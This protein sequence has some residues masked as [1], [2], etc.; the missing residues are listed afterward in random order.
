MIR[1]LVTVALLVIAACDSQSPQQPFSGVDVSHY[2]GDV[3]WNVVEAAGIHFAFAK[4]TQG[5]HFIDP[6]F[7]A[8]WSG[9]AKTKII[10]G[11]YHFLDPDVD[12]VAQATHFLGTVNFRSGDLRPVVDV[13]RSGTHLVETL[14]EFL[15]EVHKQLGIDAII[16]VSP[17]FW[18]EHIAPKLEGPLPNPLWSAEYEVDHPK[19]TDKLSAYS[20]WQYTQSGT[21]KGI[22]GAVDRD[23]ALAG[24]LRPLILN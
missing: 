2:Q 19:E 23:R 17:D 10:R 14:R 16:Y 4:A 21:V 20:I 8:N 22:S 1:V 11:A 12:G 7:D 13:E 5:D 18:N 3:D 24:K 6:K 9:L 15:A